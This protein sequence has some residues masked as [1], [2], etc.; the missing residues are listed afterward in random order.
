M[1]RVIV[2]VEGAT[3][4]AVLDRLVAPFLGIKGVYIH[5]RILGKPGRKGGTRRGFD[6]V[7][8]ELK[9]LLRQEMESTVTTFFDYYGMPTDWPGVAEAKG[10]PPNQ[11]PE[12][13]ERAIAEAVNREFSDSFRPE[14]FIPY[15]QMY[16]LEA[17]LFSGPAEMAAVF[18]EP[19]LESVFKKIV[20]DCGG[21]E[22][23]DDDPAMAPSKRIMQHYPRYR[24]GR[25]DIAHAPIIA[26]RIGLDRIR[27]A[28]PHFSDWLTRLGQLGAMR[29]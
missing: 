10:K 9:A 25:T 8:R 26:S 16:E 1:S 5:S 29:N 17:L 21:C 27:A 11:V 4:L 19:D 22:C 24:K 23:I 12:I 18:E 2:L 15:I 20:E 3:E 6:S 14:R 28:C 7:L 13:V